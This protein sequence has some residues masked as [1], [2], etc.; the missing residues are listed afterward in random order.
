MSSS[1][2]ISDISTNSN[3]RMRFT[4]LGDREAAGLRGPVAVIAGHG[5]SRPT[6]GV[7]RDELPPA[8]A[9]GGGGWCARDL[10]I[11][12]LAACAWANMD[13]ASQDQSAWVPI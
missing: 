3:S 13:A 8:V 11:V 4:T 6:A 12:N 2:V 7:S 1:T 10:S 5:D 9:V